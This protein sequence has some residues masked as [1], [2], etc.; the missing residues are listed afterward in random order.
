MT[1]CPRCNQPVGEPHAGPAQCSAA[2]RAFVFRLEI[3]TGI[4]R[5]QG[6]KP[7]QIAAWEDA[8]RILRAQVLQLQGD[9]PSNAAKQTSL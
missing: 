5:E 2:L 1:P 4:A 7:E 9:R 8:L 6:A 3:S